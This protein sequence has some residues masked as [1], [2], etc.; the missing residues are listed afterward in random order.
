MAGACSS[1]SKPDQ[2]NSTATNTDL[3][4]AGGDE[5]AKVCSSQETLDSLK[6]ILFKNV[7]VSNAAPPINTTYKDKLFAGG[8]I[9]LEVPTLSSFDRTTK[10][11]TCSARLTFTW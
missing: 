8:T 7:D 10:L 3:I 2:V 5:V 4:Q 11:V 1:C 6:Q 9:S